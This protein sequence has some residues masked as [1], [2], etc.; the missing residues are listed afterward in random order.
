MMTDK[1]Y[2]PLPPEED[3]NLQNNPHYWLYKVTREALDKPNHPLHAMGHIWNRWACEG[4]SEEEALGIKIYDNKRKSSS[5][6]GEIMRNIFVFSVV[7]VSMIFSHAVYAKKIELSDAIKSLMLGIEET[8]T[9]TY[10]EIEKV[11]TVLKE[12][13]KNSTQLP[14]KKRIIGT[15][16]LLVN[17]KRLAL[18]NTYSDHY[19]W[20]VSINGDTEKIPSNVIFWAQTFCEWYDRGYYLKYFN[21]KGFIVKPL[22]CSYDD[23]GN[24]ETLLY[25]EYPQKKPAFLNVSYGSGSG[26]TR[27]YFTFYWDLKDDRKNY[28][29]EFST[30]NCRKALSRELID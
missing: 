11:A 26:G 4:L 25:L 8:R 10:S 9:P 6:C 13:P 29:K 1:D 5:L 21:K 28:S 15:T 24:H 20:K 14:Y 12:Q 30:S 17:N 19:N 22:T 18:E 2:K 23:G 27:Y 3:E 7:I 16:N